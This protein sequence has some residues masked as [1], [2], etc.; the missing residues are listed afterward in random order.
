MNTEKKRT[1]LI[2]AAYYGA[3]VL[4][5]YF[6]MRYLLGPLSPFIAGFIIAWLLYKPSMA[7]SRRARLPRRITSM[8]V[9]VVF[10]VIVFSAALTASVQVI[11]AVEN[12]VPQIP[13]LYAKV[14]LPYVSELF[15][16]L[17]VWMADVDPAVADVV[18]RMATSLF[19]NMQSFVSGLPVMA[20]R[21]V[22]SVVTGMPNVI[23]SVVLTVISTFFISQ[24]Y[25]R[26]LGFLKSCLP[27]AIRDRVG[28]TVVTGVD[29]IRKILGSYILIMIMSFGELSLG[30]LL[31][32]VPYAVGLA[33]LVAVI[34]I[35]PVLGTGLVLI[36]WAIIAAIL[37]LY[38][39]AI[40]VA[41]LYVIMLVVRNIVEP[42]LVGKQMGLHPVATLISMFLGL[43]FFGILGLFGFPIAL[44]L[45]VKMRASSK[46]QMQKAAQ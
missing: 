12:L 45:Y 19:A 39:T 8:I 5:A 30:F 9:A 10:Y 43:E 27:A 38:P 3:I 37:G 21:L 1:F 17:D 42:K 34:D 31:L 29:S 33:L 23:L 35:M 40:G 2:N 46:E 15:E 25:E 6:A 24:D 22:S 18:E 36:P 7:L 26:V 16:Q 41:L 13:T 14:V 4:I 32:S 44:S 28:E 11:S 20:V